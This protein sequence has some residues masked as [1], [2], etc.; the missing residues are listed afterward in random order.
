M[1]LTF[2]MGSGEMASFRVFYLLDEP[3]LLQPVI[4][5]MLLPLNLWI[6]SASFIEIFSSCDVVNADRKAAF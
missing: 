5:A 3:G 1:I 4:L 2:E 6:D